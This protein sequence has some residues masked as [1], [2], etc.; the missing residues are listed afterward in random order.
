MDLRFDHIIYYSSDP[1]AVQYKLQSL[2]FHVTPGGSHPNWGTYNYL[3][4]FGLSY[5]E[6]AGIED[7]EKA[8]M[9]EGNPFVQQMLSEGIEGNCFLRAVLRTNQIDTVLERLQKKGI[10][11]VGPISGSRK[12]KNG[13][14]LNWSMLFPEDHKEDPFHL[15]F[16][17][18]WHMTDEER[19]RSLK[20]NRVIEDHLAGKVD[21]LNIPIAV[22]DVSTAA[23]RWQEL[24][25]FDSSEQY[26]DKEMDAL[27]QDID[28]NGTTIKLCQPLNDNGMI[29]QVL[30]QR[31]ERPF[32]ASISGLQ[33]DPYYYLI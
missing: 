26:I 18:D 29:Q 31:G 14:L 11:M 12:Q 27:C 32:H 4:F 15:P 3:C 33:K 8:N 9:V 2:G 19:M 6:I 1:Q 25:E 30:N 17:I 28:A 16:I 23:L 7:R 10:K 21:L 24:F 20:E 5:I 22:H 13:T